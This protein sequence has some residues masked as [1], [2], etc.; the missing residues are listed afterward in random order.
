MP[1]DVQT[2]L[3]AMFILGDA[4]SV[5]QQVQNLLDAGLDG[6]VFNMVDSHDTEAVEL[7]GDVL[8]PVLLT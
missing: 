3:R 5:Q 8:R 2:R 1:D 4:A 6:I 7:A